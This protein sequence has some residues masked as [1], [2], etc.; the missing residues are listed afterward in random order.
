MDQSIFM[1]WSIK[2]HQQQQMLNISA[3]VENDN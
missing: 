3:H 1:D 2:P